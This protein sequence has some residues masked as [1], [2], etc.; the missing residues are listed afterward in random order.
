MADAL[1]LGFSL[2]V[3]HDPR[4]VAISIKFAS[5]LW[6]ATRQNP[7]PREVFRSLAIN[8]ALVKAM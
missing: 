3:R 1:D 5:F 6:M 8:S 2:D 7:K 4:R